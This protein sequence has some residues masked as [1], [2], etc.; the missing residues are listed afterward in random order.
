MKFWTE[1]TPLAKLRLIAFLIV[2]LTA[3][4]AA[5]LLYSLYRGEALLARADAATS[6]VDNEA[7][8]ASRQQL[9]WMLGAVPFGFILAA[10]VVAQVRRMGER[11]ERVARTARRM[12]E[13]DVEPSPVDPT[14]R[15]E[16]V[17]VECALNEMVTRVATQGRRQ[18]A[19]HAA[20]RVL[21]ESETLGRA[22]P[23][24]LKAICESLGWHWSGLWTSDREKGVLRCGDIWHAPAVQLADFSA[25]SQGMTFA[26]GVGLPGRVWQSGQ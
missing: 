20:T 1:A 19:Q 15:D 21:A 6:V 23:A 11:T 17:E 8:E 4:H 25:M 10:L 18:A 12:L 3:L 26:P 5:F 24:I 2:G 22:M 7:R 16:L 9:L 13:G 14:E